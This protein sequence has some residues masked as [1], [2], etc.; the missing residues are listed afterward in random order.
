[1]DQLLSFLSHHPLDG[2]ATVSSIVAAARKHSIAA[3]PASVLLAARALGLAVDDVGGDVLEISR[4]IGWRAPSLSDAAKI[5]DYLGVAVT[6]KFRASYATSRHDRL[7]V[8]MR[9]SARLAHPHQLRVLGLAAADHLQFTPAD[10]ELEAAARAIGAR[11]WRD[12]PAL[13]VQ[14]GAA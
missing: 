1:M 11:L 13:M 8:W 2:G 10:R 7:V 4:P 3:D 5:A 6:D 9:Q 14:R 12:G